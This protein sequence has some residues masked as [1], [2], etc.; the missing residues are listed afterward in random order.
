MA[1][2][3]LEEGHNAP[4]S[5]FFAV[6]MV[7]WR[8]TLKNYL[9]SLYTLVLEKVGQETTQGKLKCAA[10]AAKLLQSCPA[11]CDPT[12]GS[13]PGSSVPGVLQAATLECQVSTIG[14]A[15]WQVF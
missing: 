13:P 1:L 12:D 6:K 8:W 5:Y 7:V 2:L 14:T 3:L 11:L 15:Q 9:K 10:A 4:L